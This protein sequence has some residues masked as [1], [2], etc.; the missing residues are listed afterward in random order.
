M[1]LSQDPQKEKHF[2][3]EKKKHGSIFCWHGSAM[4]NWYSILRNG[5]RNLSNTSLMTAGAAY[6]QGIY[7]S[8]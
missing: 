3:A 7:A 2:T 4:E 6:G 5:L 8:S 1:L